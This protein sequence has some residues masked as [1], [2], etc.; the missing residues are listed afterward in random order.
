MKIYIDCMKFLENNM[1]LNP[2]KLIKSNGKTEKI[3]SYYFGN[4]KKIEKLIKDK[5]KIVKI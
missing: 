5:V 3:N 4:I 2:I 1:R